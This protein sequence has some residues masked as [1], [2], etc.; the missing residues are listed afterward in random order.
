[1]FLKKNRLTCVNGLPITEGEIPRSRKYL[2]VEKKSTIDFY[3]LCE[4]VLT[5]VKSLKIEDGKDHILTK[6]KK[7]VNS[8]NSDHKPLVMEVLLKVSQSKNIELEIT[9]FKDINSQEN[10]K[11]ITSETQ[12]FTN[13]AK[14]LQPMQQQA[15]KWMNTLKSHCS[16]AF[17]RIRIKNRSLDLYTITDKNEPTIWC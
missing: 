16:I 12:V 2:G 4:R 11:E 5:S 15:N 9:D 10:F 17:K 6:Y 14:S 3:V 7:G 1:M 13:C 8:V